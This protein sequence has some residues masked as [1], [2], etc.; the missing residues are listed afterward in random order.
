MITHVAEVES[1][2]KVSHTAKA[3]QAPQLKDKNS[4]ELGTK[5]HILSHL[6]QQAKNSQYFTPEKGSD[7]VKSAFKALTDHAL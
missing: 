1:S 4:C 2:V 5:S 6:L 3:V 7:V